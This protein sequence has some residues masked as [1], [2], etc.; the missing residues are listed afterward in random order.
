[1]EN[2]EEY[3]SYLISKERD[4]NA[5]QEY[6]WDQTPPFANLAIKPTTVS[7]SNLNLEMMRR[8]PFL[9]LVRGKNEV[10]LQN[11]ETQKRS[12]LIPNSPDDVHKVVDLQCSGNN[13]TLTLLFQAMVTRKLKLLPDQDH[14]FIIREVIYTTTRR[15]FFYELYDIPDPGATVRNSLPWEEL[16]DGTPIRMEEADISSIEF[17]EVSDGFT[18]PIVSPSAPPD[19]RVWAVGSALINGLQVPIVSLRNLRP[20]R[21]SPVKEGMA[22]DTQRSPAF[23]YNPHSSRIL[24]PH[25]QPVVIAGGARRALWFIPVPDGE[26]PALAR[27]GKET[28]TV[29][30]VS[31]I[32][33]YA[34]PKH[35]EGVATGVDANPPDP[36]PSGS[37]TV[38]LDLPASL[39][40]DLGRGMSAHAFD[41][42][43]GRLV[44]ATA[45]SSTIH[46]LDCA[47]Y[48]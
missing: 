36:Q 20:Q 24:L 35:Q 27:Y 8:G 2:I 26:D 16:A 22:D 23:W 40:N 5:F 41:E 4:A 18:S 44:L 34:S 13:P 3:S 31:A 38:P 30:R 15:S 6:L 21:Q 12:F 32:V 7:I 45:G 11:L 19:I 1:L 47:G 43:I 29:R 28:C 17:F 33:R 25:S 14:I 37:A 42:G 46:I 9:A 39:A 10:V 48:V